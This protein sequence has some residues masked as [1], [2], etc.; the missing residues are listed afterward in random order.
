MTSRHRVLAESHQK[1]EETARVSSNT[2][3]KPPGRSSRAH[4]SANTVCI[5]TYRR[6]VLNQQTVQVQTRT[7]LILA[8]GEAKAGEWAFRVSLWLPGEFK[9]D[10]TKNLTLAWEREGEGLLSGWKMN[11]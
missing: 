3:R 1:Q 7:L 5:S 9:A 2:S 10:W 11:K 6:T 8:L 4:D